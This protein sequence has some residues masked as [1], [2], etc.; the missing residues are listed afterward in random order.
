[1]EQACQSPL[2]NTPTGLETATPVADRELEALKEHR[3]Q[4][5]TQNATKHDIRD[6]RVDRTRV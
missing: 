4:E 6:D 1:M 3:V 2:L 5:K